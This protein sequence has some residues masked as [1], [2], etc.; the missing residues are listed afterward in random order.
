MADQSGGKELC[1]EL[2]KVLNA[3]ETS[4]QRILEGFQTYR[5]EA[6]HRKIAKLGS[7]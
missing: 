7:K 4:R 5:A 1:F 6:L 3:A 2:D